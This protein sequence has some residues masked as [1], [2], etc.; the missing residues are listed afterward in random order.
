MY[1]RTTSTKKNPLIVRQLSPE[2][3]EIRKL[4]LMLWS[5]IYYI[6]SLLV[7]FTAV[8][9]KT[10]IIQNFVAINLL[11]GPLFFVVTPRQ[12]VV[13]NAILPFFLK[14]SIHLTPLKRFWSRYIFSKMNRVD[15]MRHTDNIDVIMFTFK[16]QVV[17][18]L[19]AW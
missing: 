1:R 9:L 4:I 19:P 10:R 16:F 7:T 18:T 11:S 6:F 5:Y 13:V 14:Q 15:D 3:I 17:L 8:V 12:T 2:W